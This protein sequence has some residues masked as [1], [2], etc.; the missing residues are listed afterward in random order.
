MEGTYDLDATVVSA[1][2]EGFYLNITSPGGLHSASVSWVAWPGN[3]PGVETGTFYVGPVAKGEY[4]TIKG[5]T[6][7]DTV[8][9]RQP[10]VHFAL[11]SF[12]INPAGAGEFLIR[13]TAD[14]SKTSLDW[15]ASSW[16][17]LGRVRGNYLAFQV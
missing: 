6:E 9:D 10:K 14:A 1:D 8:F 12:Q 7:F 3:H 11:S 15:S 13:L 4:Y 2:K 16:L 17:A 5:N